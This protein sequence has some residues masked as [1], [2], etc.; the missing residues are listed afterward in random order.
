VS[1]MLVKRKECLGR[2]VKSRMVKSEGDVKVKETVARQQEHPATIADGK[3]EGEEVG[4]SE[5][6]DEVKMKRR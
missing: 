5:G 6:G 3:R 4:C 2:M 1:G